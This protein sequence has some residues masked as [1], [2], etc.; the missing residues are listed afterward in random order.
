MD[1]PGVRTRRLMAGS[2][3]GQE[4][5]LLFTEVGIT[6]GEVL[7]QFEHVKMLSLDKLLLSLDEPYDVVLMAVG[8]LF[9]DKVIQVV[10]D[11]MGLLIQLADEVSVES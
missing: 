10:K 8:A 6:E 9:R 5:R 3:E 2:H 4:G 11:D 7:S 1:T